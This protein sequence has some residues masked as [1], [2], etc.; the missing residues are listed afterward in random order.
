MNNQVDELNSS[1][2]EYLRNKSVSQLCDLVS[3]MSKTIEDQ[4]YIIDTLTSILSETT[5]E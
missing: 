2:A 3:E 4:M 1:V 5:K